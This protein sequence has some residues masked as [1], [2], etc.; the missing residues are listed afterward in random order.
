MLRTCTMGNGYNSDRKGEKD[1]TEIVYRAG[2]K[3]SKVLDRIFTN[4]SGIIQSIGYNVRRG[5]YYKDAKPQVYIYSLQLET[6]LDFE[7]F[8][9]ARTRV[10]EVFNTQ[11]AKLIKAESSEEAMK[12]F[13]QVTGTHGTDCTLR[14][15]Y[16]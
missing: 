10:Y 1:M 4:R 13:V 11:H 15:I 9:R 16:D 12:K 7:V 2:R 8:K 6:V 5:W 14:E 3:D